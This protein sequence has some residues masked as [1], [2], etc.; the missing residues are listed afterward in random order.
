MK[1]VPCET[2]QKLKA[3]VDLLL[4]WNAKINLISDKTVET[5]W[6]RH[7][8]DSAQLLKSIEDLNVVCLD[9]GSGAGLP[10]IILSIFGVKKVI[11]VDSDTRKCIFLSEVK[12]LLDL[13]V[14]I[15]NTRI[16]D[17]HDIS[18][19][20]IVSRGFSSVDE[21]FY[22]VQVVN[23]TK[24]LMMKGEKWMSEIKNAQKNWMFDYIDY[25]SVTNSESRII[26]VYNLC[27]K[28]K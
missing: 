13:N 24:I 17:I 25:H 3:Y 11:L 23:Y 21:F 7:I 1:S 8:E 9:I 5:I 6:Q 27:P 16:E 20:L 14:E 2:M 4:K 12:R 28:Q 18:V 22:K 10:G 19:D 26:E 15:V